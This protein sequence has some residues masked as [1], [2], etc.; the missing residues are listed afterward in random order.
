M[1]RSSATLILL[2]LLIVFLAIGAAYAISTPQWQAPDE[3]AHYNYIKYIVEHGALPV[4]QA[5]DYDQAYNEAFTRTPRDVQIRPIDPLR[6]EN[7]S[8][9]LY[10]LLAAPIYAATEGWLVAIRLLSVALGGALV[11]V[12]YLIGAE[13]FPD[14]LH[15]ALGGAAFV[16]FVPQHV[17]MLSAVNSDVLAEL[18]IAEACAQQRIARDQLTI[19]ADNGGPMIAKPV[20]LLMSDLGVTPSHSRPHVS[21]DN[22]F[23][24]AQFKTMKY[25]PDYPARLPMSPP[26]AGWAGAW[27]LARGADLVSKIL[28]VVQHRTSSRRHRLH[29]PG[30]GSL[31]RCRASLHESSADARGGLCRSPRTFCKRST[32]SAGVAER[33]LDQPAQTSERARRRSRGCEPCGQFGG[34]R[35]IVHKSTA[36][37]SE[38]RAAQPT[39]QFNSPLNA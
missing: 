14:R 4:L 36:F 10:Y 30:S 2:V 13:V 18:L 20:T 35:R 8:P 17:A 19:H 28:S 33:G 27:E 9:P 29:D 32:V 15:I 37:V 22:P 21:N 12:A 39:R 3:P 31:R 34:Q 23:S 38:R 24:E 11:V 7:Y 25:Q 26:E 6:Y 5:G 16:A 1:S